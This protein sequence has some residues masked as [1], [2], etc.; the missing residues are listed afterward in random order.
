M[1]KFDLLRNIMRT[2][3][4]NQITYAGYHDINIEV[5]S[6]KGD[7]TIKVALFPRYAHNGKLQLKQ[8]G[9]LDLHLWVFRESDE[10]ETLQNRFGEMSKVLSDPKTFAR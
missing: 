8:G 2:A 10:F 5:A 1:D 6:F 4:S 3:Q 7:M 9:E